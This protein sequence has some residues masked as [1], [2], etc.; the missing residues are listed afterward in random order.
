M[1]SPV[2]LLPWDVILVALLCY[3]LSARCLPLSALGKLFLG[4]PGVLSSRGEMRLANW[5][6]G[7]LLKAVVEMMGMPELDRAL[8]GQ[9]R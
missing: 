7:L 6:W 3:W 4:N 8:T 5:L 1:R 9:V 2:R